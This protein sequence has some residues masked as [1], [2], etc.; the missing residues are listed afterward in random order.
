MISK[1]PE[2]GEIR[3]RRRFALLPVRTEDR[4][5]VWL[6]WYTQVDKYFSYSESWSEQKVYLYKEEEDGC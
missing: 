1:M 2:D 3:H 5:L 4:Y 6:D